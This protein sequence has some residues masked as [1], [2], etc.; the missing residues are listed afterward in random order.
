MVVSSGD[1][2]TSG[3]D[4]AVRGSACSRDWA[5]RRTTKQPSPGT[6]SPT[7]TYESCEHLQRILGALFTKVHYS[8]SR[9]SLESAFHAIQ[10]C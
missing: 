7:T 3:M 4:A 1:G 10:M 8:D 5:S 6:S 9:L 2:W